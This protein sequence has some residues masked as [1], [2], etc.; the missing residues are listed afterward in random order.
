MIQ[1]LSPCMNIC[2]ALWEAGSRCTSAFHLEKQVCMTENPVYTYLSGTCQKDLRSTGDLLFGI[3][4]MVAQQSS[5]PAFTVRCVFHGWVNIS[6]TLKK[7]K[8]K[9]IGE[10]LLS[11]GGCLD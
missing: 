1:W 8:S 4:P 7:P 3:S 11:L 2:R 9:I 6:N 5:P 10:K